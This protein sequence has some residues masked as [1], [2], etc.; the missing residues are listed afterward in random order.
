M[1]PQVAKT[2]LWLGLGP[3]EDKSSCIK[4]GYHFYAPL[5]DD[6]DMYDK[7]SPT[8]CGNALPVRTLFSRKVPVAIHAVASIVHMDA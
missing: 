5:P 8:N 1:D 6:L 3:N 4:C 2:V 7:Y